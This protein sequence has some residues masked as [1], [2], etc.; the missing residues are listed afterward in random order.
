MILDAIENDLDEFENFNGF[1]THIADLGHYL[2]IQMLNGNLDCACKSEMSNLDQ[3]Q[4]WFGFG[5]FVLY[6]DL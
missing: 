5:T 1:K 2:M 4:G 3:L 6:F